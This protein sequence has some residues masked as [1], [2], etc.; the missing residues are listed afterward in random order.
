MLQLFRNAS[1][2]ANLAKPGEPET[3]FNDIT[4]DNNMA[5]LKG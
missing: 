2:D 1:A 3:A 4:N 5:V